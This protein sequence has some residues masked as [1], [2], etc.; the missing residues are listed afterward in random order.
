MIADAVSSLSGGIELQK[1]ETR[2]MIES[3]QQAY[4]QAA[5]DPEVLAVYENV[6]KAWCVQCTLL[7][8]A[9]TWFLPSPFMR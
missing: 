3:K 4:H 5:Q 1:P 6:M 9:G 2:F 8:A 7:R